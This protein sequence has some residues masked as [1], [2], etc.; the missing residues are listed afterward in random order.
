M[1]AVE[2]DCQML[3]KATKVDGIYDK[4]PSLFTEAIKLNEISY[5]E[6]IYK[7]IKVMDQTAITMAKENKLPI[8]VCAMQ[9]SGSLLA[10]FNQDLNYCSILK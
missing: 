4:D 5:E 3:I 9:D 8:G 1:R 7:N 6:A 10:T 2:L